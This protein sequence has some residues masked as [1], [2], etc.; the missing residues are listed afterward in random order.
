[1]EYLPGQPL[2]TAL[3]VGRPPVDLAAVGQAL[4][5]LHQ[6][7]AADSVPADVSPSVDTG[8]LVAALLPDLAG[9]LAAVT[10]ALD[11][12]RP[13]S[14]S[15]A[16]CHGDFSL[17]RVIVGADGGLGFIDWDRSGCGNPAADLASVAASGLADTAMQ[18]LLAGYTRVRPVPADLA[19]Q[20]AEARLRRLAEPFRQGSPSWVEDVRRRL[21]LLE[22]TMS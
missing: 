7:D 19:W 18:R 5:R 15:T 1:V 4:A 22:A 17:D 21:S 3:A 6:V 16:L 14:A 13:Y 2:D 12:Q 11:G 20:I 9:R 8:R 10:A